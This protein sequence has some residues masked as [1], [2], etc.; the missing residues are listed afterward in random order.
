MKNRK[1][2]FGIMD[3]LDYIVSLLEKEYKNPD[4]DNKQ[5]PVDELVYIILSK[6]TNYKVNND[7]Y[8]QLKEKYPDWKQVLKSNYEEIYEIIKHGGLGEEKSRNIKDLLEKVFKDFGTFNIKSQLIEWTKKDVYSYLIT[9]PGIG[10]KSA[11]CTMLYS[12]NISV[13]PADAHVIRLFYRLGYIN[14]DQTNHHLAQKEI[15]ELCNDFLYNKNYKIHVNFKA[16]GQYVCRRKN[17]KCNEC[18]IKDNCN[19]YKK[20]I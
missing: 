6:R 20:N 4:F 5:D 10:P 11:Y 2:V 3:K 8:Y 14:Y 7:T 1:G 17:P 9:L 19:F 12:L 13:Q 18:I 16:H 15:T